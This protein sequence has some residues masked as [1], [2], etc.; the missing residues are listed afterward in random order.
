MKKSSSVR[1]ADASSDVDE[2][3][4]TTERETR[5]RRNR[6][7]PMPAEQATNG[8]AER[9]GAAVAAR[10]LEDRLAAEQHLHVPG[11]A[12]SDLR[13]RLIARGGTQ[14]HLRRIHGVVV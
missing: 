2:S 6:R 13:V 11:L 14:D 4:A 9:P 5:D 3:A 10:L 12:R 1:C 8:P 7:R